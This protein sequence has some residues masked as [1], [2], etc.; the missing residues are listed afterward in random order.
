MNDESAEPI[1][2]FAG[3]A[4]PL[5]LPVYALRGFYVAASFL[6]TLLLTRTAGAEVYGQYVLAVTTA[7]IVAVLAVAGQ[8]RILLREMAGDL[9]IGKDQRAIAMLR[10]VVRAV[11]PRAVAITGIYALLLW[12]GPAAGLLKADGAV[13]TTGALL[14]LFGAL[15]TI[16]VAGARGAGLPV[17]AQ[18]FEG[19]QTL[20]LAIAL[21]VAFMSGLAVSAIE[22]VA[23][24][25]ITLAITCII[26][27]WTLRDW[28]RSKV[29]VGQEDIALR[30]PHGF[31]F[32]TI[33]L[34][35]MVSDWLPIALI[36]YFLSVSDV[37]AFRVAAQVIL[38]SSTVMLT[39]ELVIMPQ[40]A[41]DFRDGRH[42]LVWAR[43]GRL[44][45]IMI[46]FVGP[47]LL[48][49]VL[50][51]EWIIST[52]FGP[53]FMAA[54]AALPIL[55]LGQFVAILCGPVG[56]LVAMAGQERL[57]LRLGIVSLVILVGLG[58]ALVPTYGLAG[59]AVA[60]AIAQAVRSL[61]TYQI[62]IEMISVQSRRSTEPTAGGNPADADSRVTA[63]RTTKVM[64]LMGGLPYLPRGPSYTAGMLAGAMNRPPL[65]ITLQVPADAW[66][67]NRPPVR[68]VTPGIPR[69]EPLVKAG[70]A[71]GR[72]RLLAR[73]EAQ[74]LQ[75]VEE[76]DPETLFWLFGELPLPLSQRLNARGLRV[77]REK[78]NAGK[79]L[80]RKIYDDEREA[81]GFPVVSDIRDE[82][83]AKEAEEMSLAD[84]VFCPSPLVEDSMRYIGVPEEKLLVT[85]YGWEPAR[86][87]GTHRSLPAYP[88]G[89]TFLFVGLL[90]FHKG[91]HILIEAWERAGIKGR[92]VLAGQ[93]EP[94]FKALF[95]PRME[96][97]DILH[98]GFVR[99]I[100]AV[101]RSAD[102]FI[103]PS[104]A[105]GGPQVTY[106]AAGCR[107][108]AIA[109]PAG[110]GRMTRDGLDGIIIPSHDPA[111]WAA[112]I[113][114]V[115]SDPALRE[116]MAASAEARAQQFTW[117]QVGARRIELLRNRFGL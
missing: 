115:A 57:L 65:A 16:A 75:L 81:T 24:A 61:V 32:M 35:H 14:V 40:F 5:E 116:R 34:V 36:T 66:R 33:R 9:R 7:G 95:G 42:D 56:G 100:G 110:A 37:G 73:F 54:A 49:T 64:L 117:T 94:E 31:T 53:G 3:L 102:W 70:W 112:A 62:A 12:F 25:T 86:L 11:A 113:R 106:E 39:G 50:F 45:R 80:A 22:A 63:M 28:V 47:L 46:L 114:Q 74:A 60:A 104:L 78:I 91:V 23:L 97:P 68:V 8:D 13:M 38:L 109:T 108:P 44:R 72:P 93:M 69:I 30:V 82:D 15:S 84:A 17:R 6:V 90:C 107:V 83:C 19:L 99:D 88:D 59:A 89:P 103:F 96:R 76:A 48:A 105:E 51:P 2:R 43:H 27:L 26:N 10:A 98:L 29:E 85:S 4:L 21:G 1:Y 41:G 67:R 20:L 111:A 87:Q 92:L 101:Y 58:V 79:A 71:Y 18:L 77:V 55:A 52:L